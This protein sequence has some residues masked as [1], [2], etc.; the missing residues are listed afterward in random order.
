MEVKILEEKENPLLKRKE[1][2]AEVAHPN[3]PTPSCEE[4]RKKLAEIFNV[5]VSQV[6][7]DRIAT[8][9]GTQISSVKAKILEEKPKVEE[10][11]TEK[12]EAVEKGK[13][14]EGEKSGEAQAG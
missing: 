14:A 11:V 7:I 6:V 9:K 12:A 8:S 10:K 2:R 1:I 5:D 3:A 4:V 13:E